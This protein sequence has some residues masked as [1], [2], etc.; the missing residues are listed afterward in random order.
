MLAK[1]I[2][3][4]EDFNKPARFALVA[5]TISLTSSLIALKDTFKKNDPSSERQID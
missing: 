5:T 3:N 1:D 4:D 2:Y